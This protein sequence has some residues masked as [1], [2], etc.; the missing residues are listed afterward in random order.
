[1][2]IKNKKQIAGIQKSCELAANTLKYIKQFIKIGVS[3][4]ELNDLCDE[5]IRKN[6]G[7]SACIGYKGQPKNLGEDQP[8]YPKSVC[9]SLNEVICHG[10]PSEYKLKDG[11]IF[12]ID[13]T[14][15]VN[16]YYGDTSTMFSVGNIS[17]DAKKI[18]RIAKK[19]LEIGI[20][21]VR[22]SNYIGNIGYEIGKYA[23]SQKV[24]V[25]LHFCGH[26]VGLNFHESPQI[27]HYEIEKN[28]GERMVPGAIFTIEPMI[29]LGSPDVKVLEDGWTAVTVDN[30]LSA[31]FEHTILVTERG[32]R[33]L[34]L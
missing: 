28:R 2:I 20:D 19:C 23:N 8:I 4:L 25:V 27:L 13:V 16:G 10:I 5:Y 18:L 33:I 11:D 26:G 30:K 29:N 24:G 31:Q 22:P 7:I 34:T 14:T 6:G 21:Q 1:M 12:N 3:T 17:E 15:I 9:I 32:Y